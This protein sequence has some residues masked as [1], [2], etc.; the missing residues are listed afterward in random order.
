MKGF[1][2]EQKEKIQR[3]KNILKEIRQ[4]N[5]KLSFLLDEKTN[6][7]SSDINFKNVP[8]NVPGN[9]REEMIDIQV[10]ELRNEMQNFISKIYVLD[11]EDLEIISI[12]TESNSYK[13]MIDKLNAKG[14]E[15]YTYTRKIPLICLKLDELIENNDI[16]YLKRA[17]ESYLK[18][19]KGE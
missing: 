18:R 16:G 19:I 11:S 15:E 4:L 9:A 5:S 2:Q 13:D 14:I 7:E 8:W 6:K 10:E 1:T 17:N 3:A 12:Y